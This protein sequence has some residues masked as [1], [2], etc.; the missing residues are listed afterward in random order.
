MAIKKTTKPAPKPEKKEIPYGLKIFGIV[1]LFANE[2]NIKK[3][4]NKGDTFMSYSIGVSRKD[5]E[6]EYTN[7]YMPVY[8]AKDLEKPEETG[9]IDITDSFFMVSGNG[10]YTKIALYVRDYETVEEEEEF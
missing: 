10:D 2:M 8:F 9:L 6:G 3:G 1:R 4:N 5:E 7:L